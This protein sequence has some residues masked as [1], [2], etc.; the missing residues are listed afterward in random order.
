MDKTRP[1]SATQRLLALLV[2]SSNAESKRLLR[3]LLT[4]LLVLLLFAPVL[5]ISTMALPGRMTSRILQ[6]IF[7]FISLAGLCL[8]AGTAANESSG[9]RYSGFISL[10]AL[11][12]LHPST[13]CVVRTL[14]MWR[15]FLLI[16]STRLPIMVWIHT[17]GHF[18]WSG[19][20]SLEMLLLCVFFSLSSFALLL[21]SNQN[22]RVPTFGFGFLGIVIWELI[23][24]LGSLATLVLTYLGLP[25]P[26]GVS[27]LSDTF[28]HFSVGR[29]IT[30]LAT[31]LFDATFLLGQSIILLLLG[32]FCLW[33]FTRLIY[34]EIG[35][36][37]LGI[38]GH[39]FSSD[40]E[41]PRKG[42][43]PRCWSHALSWQAYYFHLGGRKT[44]Q[45]RVA[46]YVVLIVALLA[47]RYFQIPLS[48]YRGMLFMGVGLF[49]NVL[50]T[51]SMALSKE[52][53]EQTLPSL[54]LA[55]GDP[56]D[57]F[58]G[59]RNGGYRMCFSDILLFPLTL[60]A[61]AWNDREA[62]LVAVAF[63]AA[64]G[65]SS[66]VFFCSSFLAAWTWH[67]IWAQFKLFGIIF[68]IAALGIATGVFIHIAAVPVVVAPLLFAYN[69]FLLRRKLVKWFDPYLNFNKN[70]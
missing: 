54:I 29:K 30:S 68:L 62:A 43:L 57:L 39:V 15:T 34:S 25:F 16:W 6:T 56:T 53:K 51:P 59:W 70:S 65:L 46:G 69:E 12:G 27:F 4:G 37:T 60:L 10:L 42:N 63:L 66:P 31:G 38:E 11:T 50:L 52:V 17:Q 32:L 13:W 5:V 45:G 23:C 28:A 40:D 48:Q 55:A 44:M 2:S 1:G 49:F 18:S 9:D 64:I 22:V 41:T 7:Y 67:N 26:S 61:L 36:N 3:P 14:Q 21:G 58:R 24:N 33:R 19:I 35:A 8:F 20:L 47:L